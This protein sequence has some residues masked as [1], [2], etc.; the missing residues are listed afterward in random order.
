MWRG[1]VVPEA[2]CTFLAGRISDG[3]QRSTK[4]LSE[5]DHPP[6]PLSPNPH[7]VEMLGSAWT[8]FGITIKK[9]LVASA[10]RS[11]TRSASSS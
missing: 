3:R 6:P 9:L 7:S 4:K 11:S 10:D 5:R 8:F 2:S 1:R